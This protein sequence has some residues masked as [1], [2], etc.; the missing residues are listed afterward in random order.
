[1]QFLYDAMAGCEN[2]KI[3]NEAFLH[4]KARRAKVGERVNLRNLKDGKDYLYEI[5]E[6]GRKDARLRLVF[7]S[8]LTVRDYK[9]SL[10]WAV[11]DPKTIEKTIPFLNELGVGK[12]IFVY[13]KF[14]QANF[15]IDVKRLEYISALSCEQCGRDSLMSF[16]IYK[17]LDEFLAVYKDVAL[18]NFGGK[19]LTEYKGELLFIG[20]EGGF[21]LEETCKI[22]SSYSLDTNSILRSQTAAVSVASKFLV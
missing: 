20:P 12:L 14:S 8:T 9:F 17:N 21:A 7:T 11:V 16:E 6:F 13:T 19:N 3:I 2:L 4:L 5:E 22:N 18:V 10:A 1:M 15:K